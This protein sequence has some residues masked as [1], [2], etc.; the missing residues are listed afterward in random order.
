[1]NYDAARPV[2]IQVYIHQRGLY[3]FAGEGVVSSLR[4]HRAGYDRVTAGTRRRGDGTSEEG[5]REERRAHY[6]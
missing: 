6:V 4:L 2:H 3:V 1:M 5:G